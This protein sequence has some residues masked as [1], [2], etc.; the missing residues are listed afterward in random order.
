MYDLGTRHVYTGCPKKNAT[1]VKNPLLKNTGIFLSCDFWILCLL[2][3]PT[4][5]FLPAFTHRIHFW[6]KRG[7][8]V[9]TIGVLKTA[10]EKSKLVIKIHGSPYVF[11][12]KMRTNNSRVAVEPILE[13]TIIG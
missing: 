4:F 9:P 1:R 5:R 7:F 8:Y 13:T 6:S 10:N 11:C 2:N 3:Y 12:H